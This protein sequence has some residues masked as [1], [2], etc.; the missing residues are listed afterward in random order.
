MKHD[1]DTMTLDPQFDDRFPREISLPGVGGITVTPLVL[2]DCELLLKFLDGMTDEDRRFFRCDAADLERVRWWCSRLDHQDCVPLL[3]WRGDR[4]VA[5]AILEIEREP[6]ASHNGQAQV[7]LMVHPEFRQRGIARMMICELVSLA[8]SLGV[9]GLSY[10]CAPEQTG[11]I[12]CLRHCGFR[13]QL[14]GNGASRPA[15]RM[16]RSLNHVFDD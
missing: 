16:V 9:D 15:V 2:S 4:I 1:N 7:R 3:A 8:Q 6:D 10:D 5:D 11:L 12:A 14:E 13:Q